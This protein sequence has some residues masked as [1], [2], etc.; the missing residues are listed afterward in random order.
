MDIEYNSNVENF[1]EDIENPPSEILIHNFLDL[2]KNYYFGNLMSIAPNQ[3]C[4]L[5]GVF[6]DKNSEEL[7]YPTLFYGH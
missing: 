4:S 5:M 1:E 2:K 6:K 3:E 7:N